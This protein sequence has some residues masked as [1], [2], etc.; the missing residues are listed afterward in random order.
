MATNYTVA[1]AVKIIADGTDAEKIQDIGRRYPFLMRKA[2][3]VAAKAGNSFVEFMAVMPDYFSAN[4]MNGCFKKALLGDG[5]WQGA[6]IECSPK[7]T[8]VIKECEDA[9]IEAFPT[10]ELKDGT[11][12][13]G[14]MSLEEFEVFTGYK[15]E[16]KTL[17]ST[18]TPAQ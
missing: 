4:K 1:E 7:G 2:T 12:K 11:R 16:T 3:E 18:T 8:K 9:K 6:Y 5:T 13:T 17:D 15:K 10:F 14:E